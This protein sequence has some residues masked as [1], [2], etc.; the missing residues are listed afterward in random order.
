MNRFL[1]YCLRV[2]VTVRHQYVT[3]AVDSEEEESRIH[4]QMV[5]PSACLASDVY[6]VSVDNRKWLP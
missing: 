6:V 1:D 3:M 4:E 5:T 2:S